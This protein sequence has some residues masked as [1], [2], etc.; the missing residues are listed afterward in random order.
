MNI[1]PLKATPAQT[2][3]VELAGQTAK[4][5]LRTLGPDLYFSLEGV[6][7]TRICRDRQR[8]LIDA[9]YRG[10]IGDF[11]FIDTQGTSDPVFTGLG[12]RYQ[13]VYVD[14]AA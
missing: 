8:L 6:V 12:G 11:M 7:A 9:G 10:F 13:L 1:V 14:A 3:T 2:L 5:S 4:L